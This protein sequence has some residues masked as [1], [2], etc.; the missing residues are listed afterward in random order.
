M[1]TSK[2]WGENLGIPRDALAPY[3]WSCSFGWCLA[4][5]YRKR[6]SALP[7]G[8]LEARERTLLYFTSGIEEPIEYC[9]FPAESV[10]VVLTQ[11]GLNSV[12]RLR[13]VM[14]FNIRQCQ[15]TLNVGF[16]LYCSRLRRK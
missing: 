15:D 11:T 16:M 13:A 14:S 8:P 10:E 2:S 4:E 1:S 6:R 5:G 7:Y 12:S 9:S 3:L